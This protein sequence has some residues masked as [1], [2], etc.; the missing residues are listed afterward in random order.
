MAPAALPPAALTRV[1]YHRLLALVFTRWHVSEDAAGDAFAVLASELV[2]RLTNA[3]NAG[4]PFDFSSFATDAYDTKAADSP[5]QAAA[6]LGRLFPDALSD[7]RFRAAFAALPEDVRAAGQ[8]SWAD[9]AM[10]AAR[11]GWYALPDKGP[12]MIIAILPGGHPALARALAR[13]L[14]PPKSGGIFSRRG[15]SS[16]A[17]MAA[18]TTKTALPQRIASLASPLVPTDNGAA[19]ENFLFALPVFCDH[20]GITPAQV[21]AMIGA[22]AG[23]LAAA[24]PLDAFLS[25]SSF[26]HPPPSAAPVTLAPEALDAIHS[27]VRAEGVTT[28][29]ALTSPL[30]VPAPPAAPPS[31]VTL[32]LES[33][34]TVATLAASAVTAALAQ[35]AP[36]EPTP[37]ALATLANTVVTAIRPLLLPPAVP[38]PEALAAIHDVVV[39]AVTPLTSAPP[40]PE[41]L[42]A[43]RAVVVDGLGTAVANKSCRTNGTEQ[44]FPSIL[45]SVDGASD[46]ASSDPLLFNDLGK[47][48]TISD[49]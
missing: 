45:A 24:S 41:T 37:Q 36:P 17:D 44:T 25:L 38:T 21:R 16:A 29:A 9:T 30:S 49:L 22:A 20:Y 8:S 47:F 40:T 6:V 4:T 13:A 48:Y 26:F 46:K 1:D 10:A 32:S 42:D 39:A 11:A 2:A 19:P 23:V 3:L 28:R 43:I 33:A 15:S 34:T 14:E 7:A 31:P 5:A 12:E 35:T 27:L 18:P